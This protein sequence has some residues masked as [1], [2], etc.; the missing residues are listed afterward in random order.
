MRQEKQNKIIVLK[1][2]SKTESKKTKTQKAKKAEDKSNK[3][4]NVED[5]FSQ[6]EKIKQAL[7]KKAMGFSHN[8]IV[9]EYVISEEGDVRLAKRKIT[10]KFS[11]PDIPAARILLEEFEEKFDFENMTQEELEKERERLLEQLKKEL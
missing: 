1:K 11:P 5:K 3:N 9:E 4:E 8:E 7:I 2:T 6:K 10:K